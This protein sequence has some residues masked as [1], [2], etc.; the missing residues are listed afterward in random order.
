MLGLSCRRAE[1]LL[2]RDSP[3]WLSGIGMP[4]APDPNTLW[5]AFGVLVQERKAG[6]A[7]DLLADLFAQEGLLDLLAQ[8]LTIDSTCH[9]RCHRSGRYDRI[10][11][12]LRLPDGGKYGRAARRAPARGP[13]KRHKLTRSKAV[14]RSRSRKARAMP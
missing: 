2:L 7:L 10:C 1:A 8:P 12:K 3:H 5:R 6:R 9:E 13:K 14:N 11:R 4:R